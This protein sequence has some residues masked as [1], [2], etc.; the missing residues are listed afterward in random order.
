MYVY[1]SIGYLASVLAWLVGIV[2]ASGFWSTFFAIIFPIWA[3]YLIAERLVL[4]FLM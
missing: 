2:L 3:Y 4:K 1:R